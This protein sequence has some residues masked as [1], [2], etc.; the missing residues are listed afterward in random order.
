MMQKD[1]VI[2]FQL[3]PKSLTLLFSLNTI[4][5]TKDHL[6]AINSLVS[7]NSFIEMTE[8]FWNYSLADNDSLA[9]VQHLRSLLK[10]AY[11]TPVPKSGYAFVYYSA[12]IIQTHDKFWYLTSQLPSLTTSEFKNDV[13]SL[14]TENLISKYGTHVLTDFFSGTMLEVLYSGDFGG[15]VS[16]YD[17]YQTFLK[18]MRQFFGTA[19]FILTETIDTGTTPTD[20]QMIYN[21]I[22]SKLKA[23]GLINATDYNPDNIYFNAVEPFGNNLKTQ[24]VKI[25][26][27]GIVPLYDLITDPVK[28]EEVKK[29][30][31]NYLVTGLPL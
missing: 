3:G 1:S 22:G 21:T 9:L 11:N 8:K 31:N 13:T 12:N 15:Y 28:K 20:E 18:R 19:P 14:S 17:L 29:Y 24:F 23:C 7:G 27:D 16:E 10:L 26:I 25:G 30:I 4:S 6:Q 2:P 5:F